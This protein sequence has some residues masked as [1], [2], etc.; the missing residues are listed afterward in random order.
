MDSWEKLE[1]PKL[2]L[3]NEFF[4]KLNVKSN[5]DQNYQHA[6]QVWN[7]I[8]A[9]FKKVPLGDFHDIYIAT[10]IL[11]LAYVFKTF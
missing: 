11:N 1:E 9:D 6:Q 4:S 3:K 5:S 10:Y 7:R 8:T 2:R